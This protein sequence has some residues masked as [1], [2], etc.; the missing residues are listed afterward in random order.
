MLDVF[1]RHQAINWP[2]RSFSGHWET[3]LRQTNKCLSVSLDNSL[4]SK[5]GST[6]STSCL[7]WSFRRSL[8]VR[9]ERWVFKGLRFP[10]CTSCPIQVPLFK[11]SYIISGLL[12]SLFNYIFSP[13][14]YL[15]VNTE[16]IYSFQNFFL[17]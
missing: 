16:V 14:S 9:Y 7:M 13:Y 10:P 12:K 6:F 2:N 8:T 3:I 5:S 1:N 11:V 17:I 15:I 4:H